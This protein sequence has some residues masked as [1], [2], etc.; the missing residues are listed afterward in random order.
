MCLALGIAGMFMQGY[1]LQPLIQCLGE[2][3]L[4]VLSFLSGTCHN[5]LYGIARSQGP[6]YAALILSQLT[7]T[8]VPILSSLASKGA[9]SNEQG[10]IQGALFATNAIANAVGPVSMEFV[11]NVTKDKM[12]GFMFIYAA[13]LYAV[14]TLVVSFIPA[15]TSESSSAPS[16][17]QRSVDLEEPLLSPDSGTENET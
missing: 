14:G 7:K 8:N 5:L 13:G 2:K 16:A 9:S 15:R 10:R 17:D 1:L 4:L 11:Y 6:L 3:G 12:P